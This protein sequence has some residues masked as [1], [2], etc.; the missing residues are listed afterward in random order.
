[1]GMECLVYDAFVSIF[2]KKGCDESEFPQT[3]LLIL[4]IKHLFHVYVATSR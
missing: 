2:R 1:L 3:I 4:G